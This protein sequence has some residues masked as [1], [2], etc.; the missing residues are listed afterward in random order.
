MAAIH[1]GISSVDAYVVWAHGMRSTARDHMEAVR[2]L[3]RLGGD[4]IAPRASALERLLAK[5]NLVEYEDR[6][7]TPAEARDALL[8][9]ERLVSWA[10]DAVKE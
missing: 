2:L 6:L 3:R 1:A 8:R 10:R 5:K 9:A 4:E 7:F